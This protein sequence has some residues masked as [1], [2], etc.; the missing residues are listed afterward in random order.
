MWW[1]STAS[2]TRGPQDSRG[3]LYFRKRVDC[4]VKVVVG[5]VP[6][7]PRLYTISDAS[8]LPRPPCAPSTF[9]FSKHPPF[10]EFFFSVTTVYSNIG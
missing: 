10:R 9:S 6:G 8:P 7:T 1:V 3:L 4:R 5:L 2:V